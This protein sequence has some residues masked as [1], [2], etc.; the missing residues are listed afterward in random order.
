MPIQCTEGYDYK[1]KFL[2]KF[3]WKK[4]GPNKFEIET[5]KIAATDGVYPLK[6]ITT[7]SD[8]VFLSVSKVRNS[9]SENQIIDKYMEQNYE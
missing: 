9:L 4:L 8:A 6:Y 7:L 3:G 2:E 1:V 5:Y